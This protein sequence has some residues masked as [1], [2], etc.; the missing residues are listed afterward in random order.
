MQQQWAVILQVKTLLH[1]RIITLPHLKG[2]DD[3]LFDLDIR[4]P[5]FK[6]SK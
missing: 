6:S 4:G 3:R 2:T 5:E 1:W